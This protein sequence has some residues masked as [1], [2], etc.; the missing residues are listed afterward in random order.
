[1]E[2]VSDLQQFQDNE[3]N[4]MK[5]SDDDHTSCETRNTC[6]SGKSQSF[7]GFSENRST[8]QCAS[9]TVL[10]P[11]SPGSKK[12]VCK[13]QFDKR[14]DMTVENTPSYDDEDLHLEAKIEKLQQEHM[15]KVCLDRDS[16]CLFLSC[17]HICCCRDCGSCLKF[18]PICRKKIDSAVVIYRS[19][20]TRL[21]FLFCFPLSTLLLSG[22]LLFF[23]Q[24]IY[25]SWF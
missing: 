25:F 6:L 21:H 3:E 8:L 5:I 4:R 10:L 11:A 14:T 22:N 7:S 16:N 12:L 15:C 17:R 23:F 9:A 13:K 20:F 19:W 2:L 1:M 18:C 24:Y